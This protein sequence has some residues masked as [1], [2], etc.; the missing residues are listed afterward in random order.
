MAKKTRDTTRQRHRRALDLRKAGLSYEQI[1]HR[2]DYRTT[3]G[4]YGAVMAALQ[5]SALEPADEVR[6]LEMER[7]NRLLLAVW[8][9]A[10]E[11]EERAI[12][13]ALKIMEQR[14]KLLGLVGTGRPRATDQ[15]KPSKPP[16]RPSDDDPDRVAQILCVLAE[17]GILPS[18]PTPADSSET[19]SVHSA[20]ADDQADR[21]PVA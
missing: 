16:A 11:G 1:A 20:S 10:I 4:A 21:L 14:A 18:A 15:A 12:D 8:P 19:Q 13:R 9:K 2:L 5:R 6:M 3:R 7:L 17:A